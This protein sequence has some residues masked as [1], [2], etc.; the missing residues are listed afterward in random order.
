MNSPKKILGLVARLVICGLLLFWIFNTIFLKEGRKVVE[1]D[2]GAWEKLSRTEQW[3]AAWT[4]G[5][6]E[7]R[8]SLG[9]VQRGHIAFSFVLVGG[10]ILLGVAR[11]QMVLRVQG[12]ALPFARA[13]KITLVAQFFNSFLLGSTGGDLVKAYYTARE[14]HHRKTEGVTTVFIDRLIGLGS[15][16]VFA[17]VMMIPNWALMREHERLAALSA[18]VF[19]MA[20]GCVSVLVLAFW[21]G[22]SRLWP[23]AR[24]LL[25]RL[26]KGAH[27]E[28]SL[29]AC[30]HF[31]RD[32][33]FLLKATALSMLVN[34]LCVWQMSVLAAGLGAKISFVSLLVIVP[35]IICIASLPITPSGLGV[36][37]NLWVW[38][39][40]VPEIAVPATDALTL[41]LLMFAGG[42]FWSLVGGVVYLFVKDRE[43][44]EEVTHGDSD[45]AA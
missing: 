4:H 30:R 17:C 42:L 28:R 19:V 36:R 9:N 34:L 14:T 10:T 29:D 40:A 23:G 41:S 16:L 21:G 1:R 5:P 26:P 12:L 8:A 15:M 27:L 38:M 7:L 31:G 32:G 18:F 13:L 37:E 45:D 39:L 2:G 6:V 25:R 3:H 24:P 35:M 11:W 44:L 22:L 33:G 43:H 20:A